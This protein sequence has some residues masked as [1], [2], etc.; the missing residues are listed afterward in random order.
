MGSSIDATW[1]LDSC[2]KTFPHFFS[3]PCLF[4]DLWIE[5][6]IFG[7]KILENVLHDIQENQ[8]DLE[9]VMRGSDGHSYYG[10]K[11]Y[12]TDMSAAW[13]IVELF[14]EGMGLANPGFSFRGPLRKREGRRVGRLLSS[15]VGWYVVAERYNKKELI[16]N[17]N[18]AMVICEAA[19]II[20]REKFFI[21]PHE[22][23][24]PIPGAKQL[25]PEFP[26]EDDFSQ[27][28]VGDEVGWSLEEFPNS[29]SQEG[30]RPLLENNVS[31][32]LGGSQRLSE[33]KKGF[34]LSVPAPPIQVPLPPS[35]KGKGRKKK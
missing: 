31:S 20:R 5:S 11:N 21:F 34:A 22:P 25:S 6:E 1:L 8:L 19:R 10:I 30:M 27:T 3:K 18:P 13:K 7:G 35:R 28:D 26:L 2:D 24:D 14:G 33:E 29:R 16:F 23:E 15:L 12:T 17:T 9:D 32:E 4:F